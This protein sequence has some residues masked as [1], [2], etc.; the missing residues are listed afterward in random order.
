MNPQTW[1][2]YAYVTNNPVSYVDPTGMQLMAPGLGGG[3]GGGDPFNNIGSPDPVT[4]VCPPQYESCDP[5][6]G[7]VGIGV[8]WGGGGGDGGRVGG[9]T[10]TSGS[11]SAGPQAP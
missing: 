5:G 4:G 2:R 3:G 7:G 6:G 10:P 1:N 11:G 9:G 8:G